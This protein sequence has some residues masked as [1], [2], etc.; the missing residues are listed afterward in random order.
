M[1]WI[2]NLIIFSTFCMSAFAAPKSDPVVAVVNGKTIKSSAL[3]QYYN[4]SLSFVKS[5]RPVSIE[6]ALDDLINRIIGIDNAKKNKLD[7]N[8]VVVKKMND[9]LFHAQVSKDLEG[10]LQKIQVTDKEVEDYY[11][12]NPE[13]RTAQVLYRLRTNP[14]KDDVAKALDQSMAIYSEVIKKP[15]TFLDIASRFSQ[16]TNVAVGGDLGYQPRTRL[17]P[18]YYAEIKGKKIGTITKPFRTQ[19]G[20]H[21]VK[22]LGVKTFEQINKNMYKKIIYDTKRDKILDTY[23]KKLQTKANIKIN[24][25]ILKG[26]K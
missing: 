21:V 7:Q 1:K 6:G 17:T 13:Y 2:L 8:P 9:V 19:Y 14:S 5:S 10:T 22:I 4:Q 11:Q 15:E 20:F 3:L 24:N 25:K 16:T 18:E 26:L 23:F 12:K